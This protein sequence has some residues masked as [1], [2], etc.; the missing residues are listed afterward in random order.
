MGPSRTASFLH[1]ET[2]SCPIQFRHDTHTRIYFFTYCSFDKIAKQVAKTFVSLFHNVS[3][4]HDN[5]VSIL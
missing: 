1:V 2:P 5:D 3:R 4:C